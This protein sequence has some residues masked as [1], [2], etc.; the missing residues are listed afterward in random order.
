MRKILWSCLLVILALPGS[1]FAQD[2]DSVSW[3]FSAEANLYYYDGATLLLPIFKA[4]HNKLHLEGRYNYEDYRTFSGW[5]GYNIAGGEKLQFT[6]TPMF[7]GAT[8]Q[9]NG[10]MAG[11]EMTFFLGRFELYSES[12]YLADVAGK[13][14]NFF[15]TWTDLTFSPA[16]WWW[17]GLSGQ[18]TKLY[19]TGVE[20]Q[21]GL[22]LG[23]G[24]NSWEFSLYTYNMEMPKPLFLLSI[25]F[26]F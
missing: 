17:V 15:Y 21:H 24:V 26:G 19:D 5:I 2:S 20:I 25:S 8:G 13:E 6:V 7:G 9:T 23:A 3:N 22:I 12:E 14:N 16:D 11:I 1:V 10:V 18:R 4:D